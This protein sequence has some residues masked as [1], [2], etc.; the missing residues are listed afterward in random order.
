MP[1]DYTDSTPLYIQLKKKLEEKIISRKYINQ[2]PSERKIMDEFYVSRSTV[3]QAIDE[4]VSENI[5]EKFP[6]KGTFVA[7]KP[8]DDWLGSLNSTTETIHSM[9]MKAG[10]KLI[11]ASNIETPYRVQQLANSNQVFHIKRVRY[12]DN[13]PIGV[14]NSYYPFHIGEKLKQFN[15]NDI[16][17]Y[18]L[19]EKELK[20]HTMEADQVIGAKAISEENTNLLNLPKTT[21]MLQVERRIYD[22]DQQF[23]E[24]EEASYRADMYSFR[25]NLARKFQ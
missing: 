3:R 24:Y 23:V 22:K 4:L 1:L 14:E 21:T 6:G 17:L 10:A 12:A 18:D 9:G 5:L 20:I 2:I 19:L 15:L 11:S 25:I 16:P 8:I 7:L 13:T